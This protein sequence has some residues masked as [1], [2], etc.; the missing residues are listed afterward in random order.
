V[1]YVSNSWADMRRTQDKS[2]AQFSRAFVLEY[3]S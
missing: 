2:A 3:V 1:N